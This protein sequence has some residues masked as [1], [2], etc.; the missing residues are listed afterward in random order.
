MYFEA[1]P[2]FPVLG[3]WQ[4]K[5]DQGYNLLN[6]Y[7]IKY[8]A[9]ESDQ[10]IFN[11]TFGYSFKKIFADEYTLKIVLPPGATDIKVLL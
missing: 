9:K 8:D 10:Y 6:Q 7:Y 11:F 4:T 2:R 1:V 5:W 3:G